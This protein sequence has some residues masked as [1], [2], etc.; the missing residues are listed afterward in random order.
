[1][2]FFRNI[3]LSVSLLIS[4]ISLISCD[5]DSS[6]LANTKKIVTVD[7]RADS[8]TKADHTDIKTAVMIRFQTKDMDSNLTS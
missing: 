6:Q 2:R 3:F 1:M 8:L 7:N 4:L 5:Q